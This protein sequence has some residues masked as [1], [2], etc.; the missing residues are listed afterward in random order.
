MGNFRMLLIALL[1][2]VTTIGVVACSGGEDNAVQDNSVTD[3]GTNKNDT[4]SN[5]SINVLPPG[6]EDHA[7]DPGTESN[8]P[9]LNL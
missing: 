9:L 3:Q 7:N 8:D 2:L 5:P 6:N 1:L 4:D